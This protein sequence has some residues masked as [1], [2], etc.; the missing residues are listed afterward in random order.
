MNSL[1]NKSIVTKR[2]SCTQFKLLP[3]F[4]IVIILTHRG[5][6]DLQINPVACLL[7]RVD[8]RNLIWFCFFVFVDWDIVEIDDIDIDLRNPFWFFWCFVDWD[9]VD[10]DNIDF[11]LRKV[12][13]QGYQSA[14]SKY[15]TVVNSLLM[16]AI[17]HFW[18]QKLSTLTFYLA[19]VLTIIWGL[20]VLNLAVLKVNIQGP[21]LCL[22]NVN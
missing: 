13:V 14:E 12:I 1:F 5:E 21:T 7:H 3:T 20:H 2:L 11:D 8:L 22:D 15:A 9:N 19:L 10:V 16:N 17:I 6:N 4:I 18:H